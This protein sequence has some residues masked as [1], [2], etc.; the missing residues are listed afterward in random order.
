MTNDIVDDISEIIHVGDLFSQTFD[1][2]TGYVTH[3]LQVIKVMK[4]KVE[5]T[6]VDV[7]DNYDFSKKELLEPSG[8]EFF[9]NG[10]IVIFTNSYTRYVRKSDSDSNFY[11][12]HNNANFYLVK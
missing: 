3:Y 1:I 4:D 7:P 12:K 6:D 10:K 9:V 5:V 8:N 2:G 11:I